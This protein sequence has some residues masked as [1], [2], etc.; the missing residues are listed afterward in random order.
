MPQQP[1]I[2]VHAYDSDANLDGRTDDEQEHQ[3]PPQTKAQS[4]VSFVFVSN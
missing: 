2:A 3:E 1:A 4:R